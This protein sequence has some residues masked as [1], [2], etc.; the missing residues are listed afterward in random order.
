MAFNGVLGIRLPQIIVST[1]DLRRRIDES[2]AFNLDK[3]Q[4]TLEAIRPGKTHARP[5][6]RSAYVAP[7]NE[8]E[9]K[10]AEIWQLL[11]GIDRIGIHDNF[12]ELGG[13]SLLAIQINSKVRETFQVEL[14]TESLFEQP[15]VAVLAEHVNAL[16]ALCDSRSVPAT[17]ESGREEILL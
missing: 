4:Q 10:L 5:D 9:R 7:R 1:Q 14:P 8:T 13:H 3:L 11:F 2:R 15:T 12:F 17:Q 16:M 6:L